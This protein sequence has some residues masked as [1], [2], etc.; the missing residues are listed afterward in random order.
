[1]IG[2]LDVEALYPS[3]DAKRAGQIVRERVT[4][5]QLRV[6]GVD[7]RWVLIYLSLTMTPHD[8]VDQRLTGVL[9]RRIHKPGRKAKKPTI[10]T[11]SLDQH[12]ER[13]WYPISPG[14]LTEGQRKH[15]LGCVM[16]QMTRQVLRT[17]FYEWE[18]VIYR[19]MRGGPIGLRASGPLGRILMDFWA[20]SI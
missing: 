5:S 11:A 2:S 16:E 20:L 10:L 18:G 9:P 1:M 12:E 8:K 3:I 15:L 7:W 14:S 13:W 19:Q 4:E 17:H 6:D